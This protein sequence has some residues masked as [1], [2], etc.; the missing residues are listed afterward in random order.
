VFPLGVTTVSCTGIDAS[1]NVA[2]EHFVVTVE[3]T[4]LPTILGLV[5]PSPNRNGWNNTDVAVT[6]TCSD[7]ASGV[8][9]CDGDATLSREGD[10][11]SVGGISVDTA[12][13]IATAT[14]TGI[15]I[16]KTAPVVLIKSP[17]QGAEYLLS[18]P[19]LTDWEVRDA[20]S[21][22]SN[23]TGTSQSGLAVDTSS[24]GV[25]EFSLTAIDRAG[26]SATVSHSYTVVSP[27]AD[28]VMHNTEV[29][30]EGGSPRDEFLVEGVFTIGGFSDGINLPNEAVAVTFD[31]FTQ[32]IPPASFV[33]E[34]NGLG[35]QYD[36]ASGGITRFIIRDDGQ[37]L[38]KA[39]MLR[40]PGVGLS[41]PVHFSLR[42][43]DDL[44]QA[45]I[46]L[47]DEGPFRLEV[48]Q[49]RDF[50]GTVLS[51]AGGILVANTDAGVVEVS[52]T[53]ATRIRLSQKSDAELADL[54]IGDLVAV[55][56]EEKEGEYFADK[57]VR[58][59]VKTR[60]K[61]VPGE[62]VAITDTHITVASTVPAAAP[63]TFRRAQSTPVRFHR[64]ES[65]IGVGSFVIIGAVRDPLTGLL[66]A[67]AR[68]INVIPG[69]E[70]IDKGV[71]GDPVYG[72]PS[73]NQVKIVGVL[74]G[75]DKGGNWIVN[76][77]SI[78][79]GAFT[80]VDEGLTVGQTIQIRAELHPGGSLLA[81]RAGKAVTGQGD[82]AEIKLEGSFEGI[83][84]L[85][86][87]WVISG[88]HISVDTAADTDGIPSLGQTIRVLARLKDDGSL[89][90]R[91]IENK[92]DPEN[93]QPGSARLKVQGTFLGVDA[94]ENWEV[95][96]VKFAVDQSTR[97]EG[98]PALGQPIAVEA[99]RQEDG[100][101]LA[102][103]IDGETLVEF[104]PGNRA[105]LRGRI[106]ET[107]DDGSFVIQG[108]SVARGVLT[109]VAVELQAGGF[110]EVEILI[111]NNGSLLAIGIEPKDEDALREFPHSSPVNIQGILDRVNSDGT[112]VVNGIVVATGPLTD[113]KGKLVAGARVN[114]E[115]LFKSNGSIMARELKISG[116]RSTLGGVEARIQGRVE[117]ID[118]DRLGNAGAISVNGATIKLVTLTR[119]KGNLEVGTRVT[120]QA[121][122]ADG[123]LVARDVVE[124]DQSADPQGD[125]RFVING[126]ADAIGLNDQGLPEELEFN[127]LEIEVSSQ[128]IVSEIPVSESSVQ[129]Q[130]DINGGVLI[131]TKLEPDPDAADRQGLIEF[132]IQGSVASIIND[133]DGNVVEFVLDGNRLSVQTL[134]LFDGIL[135][136]GMI[137]RVDGIVSEGQ[138]LASRIKH[139]GENREGSGSNSP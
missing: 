107:L 126:A 56:L 22:V 130:G 54:I 34:S 90:V 28:F 115:G 21:G 111:Q 67:E 14:V 65:K 119:I 105:K 23:A 92:L 131:A 101:L 19:I 112:L 123:T 43:G 46:S 47:N 16:D 36:G 15:N 81:R 96:G 137:I 39:E 7:T 57:I 10:R 91:E 52:V 24:L 124:L 118:R 32:T 73:S 129:I 63:V 37:F 117:E 1:G 116:R 88:L 38:V 83:D 93:S 80:Q 75:I 85:T 138:L 30:L 113:V 12:G 61:H 125:G 121:I 40:L 49:T 26:N 89:L 110:V 134:T 99:V 8:V 72:L 132:D 62:V 60:N 13:N 136:R 76:G 9:T 120:V 128:A 133:E 50:F 2:G 77:A 4:S 17:A 5:S 109:E 108:I 86:G 69:L 95:N 97:M 103:Y 31:G 139:V 87:D 58:V 74:E 42:I 78:A 41:A 44:G 64:G 55:S 51:V 35:F 33:R 127:G 18:E 59:P 135:E 68:E 3:D 82:A 11:Q 45:V 122:I 48:R 6:F 94:Q 100:S 53:A 106:E 25:H 20:L 102:Q 71:G 29:G 114:L 70:A 98:S 66:S 27:F 84:E 104:L 79:I